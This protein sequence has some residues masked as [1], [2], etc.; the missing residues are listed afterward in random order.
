MNQPKVSV[1]IPVFNTEKYLRECLNSVVNQTLKDIEILCV[2]DGST[3]GS[4]A[5]LQEYE[6]KDSRVAV[7]TQA[8]AGQSAARNSGLNYACGEYI[9]FID[10]DDLLELNALDTAYKIAK[11]NNLD[12]I[13]FERKIYY[14]S[15]QL[16]QD[17]PIYIKHI[18]ESTEVMSGIQYVIS[19]KS[20]GTYVVSVCFALWRRAFL[21]K[22]GIVFKEGII[23]E[24]N[25]FSFL[26]YMAAD[27]VMRIPDKFYLRR[28]REDSTMTSP[29]SAKNIIGYFSCAMGVLNYALNHESDPMEKQEIKRE[30]IQRLD[31]ARSIY[32]AVSDE[33]KERICFSSETE[34]E[35]F[36]QLIKNRVR[37]EAANEQQKQRAERLQEALDNK[38]KES[39][40][41]RRNLENQKK[42]SDTLRRDLENQKKESD[43]LRRDLE[44]QEKESDTLRRDLEK[45][46]KRADTLQYDLDC[47]HDSVSFRVG[48]VMTYL[49]RK[50]RDLYAGIRKTKAGK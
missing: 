26:A 41:L 50:L 39:D 3:D 24:D 10:S 42:E 16:A 18:T 49:P 7:I 37:L 33:E 34:N 19:S 45:Q 25:L 44:K 22:H 43:T 38:K 31:A 4:L 21:E 20:Q 30:Y 14:E 12:I 32:K 5:I 36:Q 1:I 2:D 9:Y 40:T 13:Q 47:V 48:R 8:H 46:K 27:R 28:V 15:E 35:L 6:G 29:K 11:D 17:I 23:H